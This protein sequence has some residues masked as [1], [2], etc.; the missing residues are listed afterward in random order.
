MSE[1]GGYRGLYELCALSSNCLHCFAA[2][3]TKSNLW[4]H[5]CASYNRAFAV[6]LHKRRNDTQSLGS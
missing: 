6:Q 2:E 3:Y 5:Y 1:R 4:K